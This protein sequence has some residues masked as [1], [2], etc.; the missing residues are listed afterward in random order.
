MDSFLAERV[1][2]ITGLKWILGQP[3]P[4]WYDKVD[5]NTRNILDNTPIRDMGL[6]RYLQFNYNQ[7]DSELLGINDDNCDYDE[8]PVE[9]YQKATARIF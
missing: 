5:D 6:G 2:M 9:E 4:E 3:T 7:D 1:D 8:I